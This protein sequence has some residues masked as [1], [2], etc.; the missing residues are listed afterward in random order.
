MKETRVKKPARDQLPHLESD[1]TVE[2]GYNKMADRPKREVREQS[3]TGYRLKHENCD[4]YADQNSCESRHKNSLTVSAHFHTK[5]AK[6]HD[7]TGIPF[8]TTTENSR[9]QKNE[10]RSFRFLA[11][12]RWIQKMPPCFP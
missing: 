8:T 2:L 3:W 10:T 1:G 7:L 12:R 9:K 5:I 4:I 11:L 6:G